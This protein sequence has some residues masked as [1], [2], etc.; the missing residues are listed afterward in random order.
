MSNI[1]PITSFAWTQC[2]TQCKTKP[3]NSAFRNFPEFLLSVFDPWLVLPEDV[4]PMDMEGQLQCNF[5]CHGFLL[6]SGIWNQ[7]L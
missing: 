7:N 4:V 6:F 5:L 2:S 1:I 3:S